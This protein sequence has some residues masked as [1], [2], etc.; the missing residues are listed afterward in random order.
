MIIVF[1][2]FASIFLLVYGCSEKDAT[3]I[4]GQTF[5]ISSGHVQKMDDYPLYTLEYKLDYKFDQYLQN[6]LIPAI[7]HVENIKRDFAC[8]CFSAFG[9]G[10]RQEL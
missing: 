9:D 10:N 2:K 1:R 7:A 8:T 6:G 5:E 4:V 3:G